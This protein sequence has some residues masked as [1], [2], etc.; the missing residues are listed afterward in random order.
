MGLFDFPV[1]PDVS[2]GTRRKLISGRDKMKIAREVEPL[3]R[4]ENIFLLFTIVL[5]V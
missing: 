2:Q 4:Q 5:Y 3:D 1:F